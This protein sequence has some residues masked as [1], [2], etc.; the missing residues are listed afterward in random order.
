MRFSLLSVAC[1]FDDRFGPD[2]IAS[3]PKT[4][5]VYQVYDADG[6]L[7]YVGKAKN[8]RRRLEQYRNARRRKK[9]RKMRKILASASRLTWQSCGSDLDALLLENKLIQTH[10]P[11]FNVAGAFAFMYP[12]LGFT[13]KGSD[14]VL[15]YTTRPLEW[16][17]MDLYGAFRSRESTRL[18]YLGLC[19]ILS[20]LGHREPVRRVREAYAP[21]ALRFSSVAGFRQVGLP[22]TKRICDLLSGDS[23]AFVSEA[24]LALLEKPAARADAARVEQWLRAVAQFYHLEARPLREARLSSGVSGAFV[25]QEDRDSLFL[26]WRHAQADQ[27]VLDSAQS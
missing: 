16:R 17:C 14:L 2:L 7:V 21:E 6:C 26:K 4:P 10:R 22:W 24:S 1:V 8:L 15:C 19:S 18:G 11:R 5:G 9:H 20:I 23:V 12:V 13:A 25:A 27:T 3:V